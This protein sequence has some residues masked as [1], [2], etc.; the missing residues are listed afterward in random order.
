MTIIHEGRILKLS[1][2]DI[3]YDYK[4]RLLMNRIMKWFNG[5]KTMT[6]LDFDSLVTHAQREYDDNTSN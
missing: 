3:H 6:D 4:C 5:G 1:D 2:S